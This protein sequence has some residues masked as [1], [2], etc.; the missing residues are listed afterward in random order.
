MDEVE[1]DV[2]TNDSDYYI[3][4]F[5]QSE[6]IYD[7]ETN[8]N[9]TT[10]YAPLYS[11]P[12]GIIVLLSV[13]YGAISLVAVL[14]NSLV[15]F[16]VCTSKRMQSVTNYFIANLALADV[17]IGVF[18]IPFQFQAA[19]LQ[20]WEHLPDLL[21]PFCPFFQNLSVNASIFTL[22]AIAVDRFRAIMFPLKSHTSKSRTKVVIV[23]IWILSCIL[24]VPMAI[25]F[26][27]M[28]IENPPTYQCLPANIP[29]NFFLWYRNFLCLVQYFIPCILIGGAYTM[30]AITL[31]STKTPGAAQQ[32]RD[33]AVMNNKKK[34]IK[35]LM[36][37]VALFTLA[38]LPLQ[39]YDVLNQIFPEINFYPYI[40]IIWF[41]CHWLA[42]SN[43]CYNPFIYLLCNEKF[44]KELRVKFK[45]CF[46]DVRRPSMDYSNTVMWKSSNTIRKVTLNT[47]NSKYQDDVCLT[48]HK[49]NSTVSFLSSGS[50]PSVSPYTLVSPSSVRNVDKCAINSSSCCNNGNG[51]ITNTSP[52]NAA[53]NGKLNE[54]VRL[55]TK[56]SNKNVDITDGSSACGDL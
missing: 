42:M 25:A 17:I 18:A 11:P 9:G 36:V 55:S 47:L 29:L 6:T 30:M 20:T 56:T 15:I 39:L 34:V 43:S 1:I 3:N 23:I 24:A 37:V 38:W 21:C 19:L 4:D 5:N 22:T 28:K 8:Y 51:D 31:W 50:N 7:N 46:N 44:K 12:T 32:D 53:D 33:L 54:M 10:G 2:D 52:M 41:C 35:M 14:G 48:G 49:K 40:N 27:S 16:I 26:R 13:F 45:C